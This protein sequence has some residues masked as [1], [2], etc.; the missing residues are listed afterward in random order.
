MG[1]VL[2]M[3]LTQPCALPIVEL[4]DVIFLMLC[5]ADCVCV[6]VCVCVC[7]FLCVRACVRA[8]LFESI[9]RVLCSAS[10]DL[11]LGDF[12]KL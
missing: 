12:S 3:L 8:C 1:L 11:R 6:R 7:V 4:S 9:I 2:L 10:E 5:V